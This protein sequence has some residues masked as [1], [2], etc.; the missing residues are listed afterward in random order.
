MSEGGFDPYEAAVAAG[1]A[2]GPQTIICLAILALIEAQQNDSWG[3]AL[4]GIV[5]LCVGLVDVVQ[6]RRAKQRDAIAK[7]VRE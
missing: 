7:N 3:L 6:W 1:K 4:I 2:A 5:M